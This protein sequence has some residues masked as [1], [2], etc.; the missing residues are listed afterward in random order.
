MTDEGYIKF[1]A[2]WTETPALQAGALTELDAWRRRLY[3][4]ALI[5]AYDD[6]IGYGNISRRFGKGDQFIITGSA[7]GNYPTLQPEHYARVTAVDIEANTLWCEGPVVASSESMSHAAVYRSCPW[8]GGVIH[9][10]HLGMWEHLLHRVPTTD[11]AATYGSPEMARSIVDLLRRTDL[12]EQKIFVM[13]G[14]REGIF[15][16]GRDLEEAGQVLLAY[17]EQALKGG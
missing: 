2:R 13:E 9:I 10:H 5:G 15:T 7:T 17:F 14:H 3:G 16:F 4:L 8:V 6:G 11:A 12:P 1:Q